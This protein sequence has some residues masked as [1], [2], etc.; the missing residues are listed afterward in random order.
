MHVFITGG[1]GFIGSHLT[2]YHLTKGDEVIAV[3]DLS[4]GSYN[5]IAQ[6]KNNK[7]FHFETANILTWSNMKKTVCWADRIYH[8]AA[9]VGMFRTLSDPIRVL[10]SNIAGCECLLRLLHLNP[11]KPTTLIASSSEVYGFNPHAAFHEEN[12]FFIN[13]RSYIQKSYAISKIVDEI[14]GLAYENKF[15]DNIIVIRL[16]NTIGPRQT[17]RYGMVVPRFIYQAVHNQ[18]ITIYGDG[19][20][21]RSF[22]DVRDTVAMLDQLATV[23]STVGNIINVGNND[24]ISMEA[25]AFLVQELAHSQSSFQYLSYQEA[26][27]T[28]FEDIRHRKP[29]LKKMEKF[30]SFKHAWSLQDTLK[31]LIQR[32]KNKMENA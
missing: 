25:L 10:E 28:M 17:G 15:N 5:N 23:P 29:D 4:T 18:P 21:K 6:F 24:E 22:C 32:E 31:D 11:R 8:M 26:Y 7:N 16:F 14:Y 9:I 19:K 20:Q 30:I 3:D 2:A 12:D 13:P 1:A 27:G